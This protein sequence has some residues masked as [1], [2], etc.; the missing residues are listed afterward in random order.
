M[1]IRM[2]KFKVT[3]YGTFEGGQ[4]VAG[5]PAH[6]EYQLM[7]SGDAAS[8]EVTDFAAAVVGASGISF[9]QALRGGSG[10]HVSVRNPLAITSPDEPVE[11]RVNFQPGECHNPA[12]LRVYDASGTEVP[13]QWAF[14]VDP[15]DW[16][17][18]DC[19]WPDGSVRRG[20]LHIC[21]D[22]GPSETREYSVVVSSTPASHTERVAL[23]EPSGTEKRTSSAGLTTRYD[24]SNAFIPRFLYDPSR[25]NAP[26]NSSGAGLYHRYT[27]GSNFSYTDADTVDKAFTH[28]SAGSPGNGVVFQEV[29]SSFAWADAPDVV[30]RTRFRHYANGLVRW[31]SRVT[32]GAEQASGSHGM[33]AYHIITNSSAP[34]AT[35]NATNGWVSYV[36]ANGASL[37]TAHTI[38]QMESEAFQ[39]TSYTPQ[40]DFATPNTTRLGWS[41]ASAGV[42]PAGSIFTFAGFFG[43]FS[44][45]ATDAGFRGHNPVIARANRMS[46]AE[47]VRSMRYSI[48][49]LINAWA[50]YGIND[51]DKSYWGSVALAWLVVAE[52]E[53]RS[54]QIRA[55]LD[56]FERWAVQVGIDPAD[57]ASWHDEWNASSGSTGLEFIGPN[58]GCL[59]VIRRMA[60]E[61]GMTSTA[62]RVTT[63]IHAMADFIVAAEVTSGGSGQMR[64]SYSE[65]DNFNAE[66]TAM[67]ILCTSLAIEADATRQATL[68]AIV[69]RFVTGY[70][71]GGIPSKTGYSYMAPGGTLR[72]SVLYMRAIY[73]FYN[74]GVVLHAHRIYPCLPS[75]PE[76]RQFAMEYSN[77]LQFD[78][79][80]YQ[81]QLDRRGGGSIWSCVAS[82]M[83]LDP[84]RT[85]GDLRAAADLLDYA[86][87]RAELQQQGSDI[88]M[89]GY[90]HPTGLDAYSKWG[91]AETASMHLHLLDEI[92]RGQFS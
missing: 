35:S 5:L 9:R 55:S 27:V 45:S 39:L 92:N 32:V 76:V 83:A 17:P 57:S 33:S 56:L 37:I 24:Q 30:V 47:I 26:L 19:Y 68:D 23:T 78:E 71:T 72:Q 51:P 74:I 22:L 89:D 59:P 91:G 87:G 40:T 43:T 20:S 63:Y 54:L 25:S 44:G 14:A 80:T 77:G 86:A 46:R 85:D 50:P 2:L 70:T 31:L 62:A 15:V 53:G 75:L 79:L 18:V 16:E 13:C 69:A 49:K 21:A 84:N 41:L 81:K 11:L 60:L 64:L 3:P 1:S 6:M 88:L 7:E 10:Q 34:A 61:Q 90:I 8:V 67:R 36:Y 28:V 48:R 82:V 29:E 52:S 73:H 58:T 4:V 65:G 38:S 42:L 12:N 66:A